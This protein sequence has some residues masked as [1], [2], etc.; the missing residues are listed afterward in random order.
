MAKHS[1]WIDIAA[2][3]F[4][5]KRSDAVSLLVISRELFNLEMIKTNH[6]Q[7]TAEEFEY[8]ADLIDSVEDICRRYQLFYSSDGSR[9]GY[10]YPDPR[11]G[12]GLR[13]ILP[14]GKSNS[15]GGYNL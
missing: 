10:E 13:F 3:E 6:R 11:S 4:G 5:I 2:S 14:S 1:E 8:E 9:V 12:S 15:L 7:L